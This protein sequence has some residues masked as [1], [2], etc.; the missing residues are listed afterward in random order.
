MK[1]SEPVDAT[2]KPT[3][4]KSNGKPFDRGL[5]LTLS[6][7]LFRTTL[8]LACWSSTLVG[9][10]S[11]SIPIGDTCDHA[12]QIAASESGVPVSVLR[13]ITRTETGRTRAGKLQPWPWTVNMEG[14][15]KWFETEDA[16]RAY[17]FKHFKGGARSF[18]VGCFQINYRW[19]GEAFRSIDE[20]FDPVEN[21]RYAAS[22][23][24]RLHDETQDWSKAAGAYHSRTPKFA[25]RYR[26]RFDEIRQT[27]DVTPVS[28]SSR[29]MVVTRE[30]HEARPVRV[31]RYPLLRQVSHHGSRGSLVPLGETRH[32]PIGRDAGTALISLDANRGGLQP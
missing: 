9:I 26:T 21:A 6:R 3:G 5:R 13:S 25:K 22:F 31:N 24:M 17:V 16:A 23:L 20:M 27:M 19:H 11:A 29:T 8:G 12:A 30:T 2:V 4:L 18:D 32:N 1:E 15:G 28:P 14:V 10:A 7:A